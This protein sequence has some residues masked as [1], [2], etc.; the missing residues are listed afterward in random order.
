MD[1]FDTSSWRADFNAYVY[2]SDKIVNL[3]KN[4]KC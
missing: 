2:I 3:M 1:L 4:V